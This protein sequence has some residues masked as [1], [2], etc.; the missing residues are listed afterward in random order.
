MNTPVVLDN[1]TYFTNESSIKLPFFAETDNCNVFAMYVDE[2]GIVHMYSASGFSDEEA[3]S[4]AFE[5]ATE[6]RSTSQQ[7]SSVSADIAEPYWAELG[8]IN[9]DFSLG[10]RG[11]YSTTYHVQKLINHTQP[12]TDYFAVIVEQSGNPTGDYRLDGL[13][14][15][16]DYECCKIMSHGPNTSSGST[17]TSVSYELGTGGASGG[18]SVSYSI[19]DVVVSNNTDEVED[20][21]DIYHDIDESKGVGSHYVAMPGVLLSFDNEGWMSLVEIHKVVTCKEVKK[22]LGLLTSYE[23]YIEN[24]MYVQFNLFGTTF[25]LTDP[26]GM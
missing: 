7:A 10:G 21:V 11:T 20:I 26:F 24:W 22:L 17:S 15:Y 1:P 9:M 12:G 8:Y 16:A 6:V 25:S 23:D 2:S 4:R 3:Q 19:G 5:W 14:Y 18:I 13:G